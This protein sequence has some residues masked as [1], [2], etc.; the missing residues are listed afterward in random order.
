[1]CEHRCSYFLSEEK[2]DKSKSYQVLG[3]RYGGGVL[4]GIPE[5][6][7]TGLD[8]I[9]GVNENPR[10][11]AASTSYDEVG[12]GR[13]ILGSGLCVSRQQLGLFPPPAVPIIFRGVAAVIS[14]PV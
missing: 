6:L 10:R 1:M 2:R 5:E 9:G 7:H 8:E 14:V 4:L 11:H 12:V 3:Y 13:Q